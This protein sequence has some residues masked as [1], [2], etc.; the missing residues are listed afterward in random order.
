ME[1]I[2]KSKAKKR[3]E[4]ERN[5]RKKNNVFQKWIKRDKVTRFL[6]INFFCS[7]THAC[8]QKCFSHK[9]IIISF[10]TAKMN[11]TLVLIFKLHKKCKKNI[12]TP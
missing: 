8:S 4:T 5:E 6:S 12:D 2:Q 10:N 7:F 1:K 3:N 9:K 11:A